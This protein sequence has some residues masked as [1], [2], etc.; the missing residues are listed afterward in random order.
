MGLTWMHHILPYMDQASLY[1]QINIDASMNQPSNANV[2]G[3]VIDG[4]LCPSDA[5]NTTPYTRYAGPW[6]RG[7]YGANLGKQL[8]GANARTPWNQLSATARGIMGRD[9]SGGIR[10]ATDGSSL[11]VIVWEVR[12]GPTNQDVRGTWAMGRLGANLVSGCDE[13][14][15]CHGI[16]DVTTNGEDIDECIATPAVGMPCHN[17][18]DGQS[19]PRSMHEGGCHAIM[20][21]GSVQF[22]S[23]NID[24]NIFRNLNSAAGGEVIGNF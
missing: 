3:T 22:F 13:V 19:A 10:D 11:T 24:F 23:E 20:G 6:A 4:Y 17:G 8:S 16:N 5:F 1:N 12:S 21:D 9:V 15:D 2:R 18:N 7:N 14:G